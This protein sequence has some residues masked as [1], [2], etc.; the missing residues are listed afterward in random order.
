MKF[1][2]LNSSL[3]WVGL[4]Y[5]DKIGPKWQ[6]KDRFKKFRPQILYGDM[7]DKTIAKEVADSKWQKRGW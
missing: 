2:F 3:S 4:S 1:Q 7:K 5:S 6:K